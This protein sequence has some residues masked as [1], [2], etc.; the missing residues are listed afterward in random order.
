MDTNLQYLLANL[1]QTIFVTTYRVGSHSF[2]KFFDDKTTNRGA[3][4]TA[5]AILEFKKAKDVIVILRDPIDR[6]ES[7]IKIL[8]RINRLPTENLL[9]NVHIITHTYPY[10]SPI[11]KYITKYIA[12]VDMPIFFPRAGHA[13][14]LYDEMPEIHNPYT[15]NELENELEACNRIIQHTSCL[16]LEEFDEILD[17]FKVINT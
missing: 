9:D 13:T 10:L 2:N 14:V 12:W 5:D 15:N 8:N 7:G 16:T 11:E 6:Y 1:D 3:Y 4:S 17:N